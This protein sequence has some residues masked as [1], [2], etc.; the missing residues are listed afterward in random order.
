MASDAV[1]SLQGFGALPTELIQLIFCFAQALTVA[2]FRKQRHGGY[3][4]PTP[5]S[6]IQHVCKLWYNIARSIPELWTCITIL[7]CS[8]QS[9][10]ML[11]VF[12]ERSEDLPLHV[13]FSVSLPT[14]NHTQENLAIQDAL[15]K[16]FSLAH[17]LRTL[18]IVTNNFVAMDGTIHCHSSAPLLKTL[19]ISMSYSEGVAVTPSTTFHLG[20]TPSIKSVALRGIDLEADFASVVERLEVLDAPYIP[21]IVSRLAESFWSSHEVTPSLRYLTLV[22]LPG[23]AGQLGVAF[24]AYI[25]SLTSLVLNDIRD[26]GHLPNLLH[27]PHLEN[28]SLGGLQYDVLRSF[29]QSIRN[30]SIIFPSLRAFTLLNIESGTF[31]FRDLRYLGTAFPSIDSLIVSNVASGPIMDVLYADGEDQRPLWPKLRSLTFYPVDLTDLCPAIS[32]RSDAGCPLTMLDIAPLRRTDIKSLPWLQEH[33]PIVK[34][35]PR[36]RRSQVEKRRDGVHALLFPLNF[37]L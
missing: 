4:A 8:N 25:S 28:L 16:I 13:S 14:L 10:E 18:H 32:R 24:G 29:V 27:C 11:G 2:D 3:R 20:P 21:N 36:K 35:G 30:S 33:V 15:D 23:L 7:N 26:F 19:C 1:T 6:A 9:M 37:S 17:R 34:C 22:R 31:K 5:V 12:A